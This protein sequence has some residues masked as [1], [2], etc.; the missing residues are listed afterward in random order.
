M[1]LS[2]IRHRLGS[3]AGALGRAGR[4][5][6]VGGG[7]LARPQ[8]APQRDDPGTPDYRWLLLLDGS[9][10]ARDEHGRVYELRPGDCFVRAPL[11]RH[12]VERDG[13]GRWLEF[14]IRLPLPLHAAL[15]EAGAIDP[16]QRH[17]QLTLDHDLLRQLVTFTDRLAG[18]GPGHAAAVV[19]AVGE[20]LATVQRASSVDDDLERARRDLEHALDQPLDL[21]ALAARCGLGRDGFRL[22][23]RR[24]FGSNPKAYR[25]RARITAAQGLLLGGASV[26]EAAAALGYPDPF[27]FSKQ[28]KR[29]VGA[30]PSSYCSD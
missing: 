2:R 5:G 9:G 27:S 30:T 11:T 26:A 4:A 17:F 25:I 12:R 22:A 19:G 13:D 10:R 3:A 1:D 21:H 29:V 20:L 18:G 14:F 8:L 24:R 28:F 23:F 6:V 15:V 16:A 7:F